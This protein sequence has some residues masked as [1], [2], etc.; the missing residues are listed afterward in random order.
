MGV[1]FEIS[2]E[3]AEAAKVTAAGAFV[4]RGPANRSLGSTARSSEHA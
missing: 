3:L 2:G 1:P 4:E